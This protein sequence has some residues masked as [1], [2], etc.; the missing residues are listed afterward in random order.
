MWV[1]R[2][3]FSPIHENRGKENVLHAR[4]FFTEKISLEIKWASRYPILAIQNKKSTGAW[5]SPG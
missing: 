2:N 5:K 4:N 3:S 1:Y